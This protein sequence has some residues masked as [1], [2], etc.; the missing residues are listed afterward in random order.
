MKTETLK[1][2]KDGKWRIVNAESLRVVKKP[3]SGAPIDGGG[4]ETVIEADQF[5]CRR[6][7]N[8]QK[9]QS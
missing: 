3:V 2:T 6:R 4:F 1:Q 5:L 7:R 9:R 8:R